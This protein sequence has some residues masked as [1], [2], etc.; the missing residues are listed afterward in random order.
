MIAL[1]G[2]KAV[3]TIRG[4]SN[5]GYIALLRQFSLGIGGG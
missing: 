3:E 2:E 1:A 4:R 5:I